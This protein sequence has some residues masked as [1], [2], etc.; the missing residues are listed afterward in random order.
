VTVEEYKYAWCKFAH[1]LLLT[2]GSLPLGTGEE[3]D[4]R[5]TTLHRP[6]YCFSQDP[7]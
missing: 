2:L 6:R 3:G 4:A 5:N 1:G 7:L